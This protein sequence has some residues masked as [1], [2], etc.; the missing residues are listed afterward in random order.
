LIATLYALDATAPARDERGSEEPDAQFAFMDEL[1]AKCSKCQGDEKSDAWCKTW[2]NHCPRRAAL[3]ADERGS[4]EPGKPRPEFLTLA[5]KHGA[6]ITGT[7]DGKNPIEVVFSVD[8]WRAF[9]AATAPARDGSE[10][11]PSGWVQCPECLAGFPI[12]DGKRAEPQ[13]L[14][15]YEIHE[16]WSS[17]NGLEDCE[18]CKSV[19]FFTVVRAVEAKLAAR[20]SAGKDKP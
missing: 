20:A 9:D 2:G 1:P 17:E 12:K 13:G 8:A 10:P 19:D 14:T 4:A 5:E 15:D 11:Q 16:W 18:M 6:R 3:K 7:P